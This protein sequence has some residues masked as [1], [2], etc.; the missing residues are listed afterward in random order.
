[1]FERSHVFSLPCPPPI[2]R[3]AG[4][5]AGWR[6][7]CRNTQFTLSRPNR[8][9]NPHLY[10]RRRTV[11]SFREDGMSQIGKVAV[12]GAGTMGAQIASLTALSGYTVSLWDDM[13]AALANGMDRAEREIF[14]NLGQRR[15]LAAAEVASGLARLSSAGSMKE[16][17]AGADLVIEAVREEIGVKQA[18]FAEL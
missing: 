2:S 12:I 11:S 9:R 15:E 5:K 18:V 17:V 8:S 14:P 13:D 4:T 6:V 16:A 10:C 1:M 7:R 3:N